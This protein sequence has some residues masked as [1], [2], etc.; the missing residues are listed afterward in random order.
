MSLIRL[1][2][3]VRLLR[4]SCERAIERCTS[5][6]PDSSKSARQESTRSFDM[7]SGTSFMSS[8]NGPRFMVPA[9]E[10]PF[11][12][13]HVGELPQGP[14]A[15]AVDGHCRRATVV[16]GGA[17]RVLGAQERLEI[18][19][20]PVRVHARRGALHEPFAAAA[21]RGVHGQEAEA[22]ARIRG[23][24]VAEGRHGARGLRHEAEPVP[25]AQIHGPT[26]HGHVI[27][28]GEDEVA[29]GV[30]SAGE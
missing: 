30:A 28:R 12:V 11:Q 13:A 2:N 22:V 17:G 27:V 1:M 26:G 15:E 29:A 5:T 23:A 4:C 19:G 18:A 8:V 21:G 25:V 3:A 6:P 24:R 20:E 9:L 16:S 7:L 14:L 10:R